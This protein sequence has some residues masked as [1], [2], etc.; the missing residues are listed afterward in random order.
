MDKRK[1]LTESYRPAGSAMGGRM[2]RFVQ[3][4]ESAFAE[5]VAERVVARIIDIRPFFLE[6][7]KL[8]DTVGEGVRVVSV[9]ELAKALRKDAR[10]L[11]GLETAGELPRRRRITGRR[12]GYLAHEVDGVPAES[13]KVRDH[14]KLN[15][16]NLARKLGVHRKTVARMKS[17]LP[18]TIDGGHWYERDIDEWLLSRPLA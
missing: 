15:L 2:L 18:P 13:V 12:V 16:E 1:R 3:L 10:L 6:Q 14:R 17:E 11:K 7:A 9:A 4:D 5:A 8:T